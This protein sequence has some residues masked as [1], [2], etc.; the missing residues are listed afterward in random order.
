MEMV[1][2]DRPRS[3]IKPEWPA[4][5]ESFAELNIN[6]TRIEPL[7]WSRQALEKAYALVACGDVFQLSRSTG[8]DKVVIDGYVH[9]EMNSSVLYKCSVTPKEQVKLL[10]TIEIVLD[11]VILY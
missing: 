1:H 11:H 6:Q 2:N 7:C 3:L 8:S 5:A 10:D 4:L 9:A